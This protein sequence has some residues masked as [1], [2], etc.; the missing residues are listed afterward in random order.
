MITSKFS[1]SGSGLRM[2]VCGHAG[3]SASGNDIVCAAVSGLVY[4]LIG[5]LA[6]EI[7]IF[8]VNSF[9]AGYA[10]VECGTLGE[11]AMKHC[12]IGLLQIALTYPDSLSVSGE[13]WGW[14]DSSALRCRM[15]V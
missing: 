1:R 6:N 5:Y 13:A 12:C 10:D 7:G 11:G 15:T 8:K 9:G 14:S 3:H 4:A 2:T